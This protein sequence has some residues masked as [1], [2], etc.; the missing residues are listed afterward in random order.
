MSDQPVDPGAALFDT[1]GR[2]IKDGVAPQAAG[3][4]PALWAA[5][6]PTE[7]RRPAATAAEAETAAACFE[8]HSG[9]NVIQ[10]QLTVDLTTNDPYNVLEGSL[11]GGICT[12][13]EDLPWQVTQGSF[14]GGFL[15][16]VGQRGLVPPSSWLRPNWRAAAHTL[17]SSLASTEVQTPI[18]ACSA[19]MG[20]SL[21][22]GT[23]PFSRV[24]KLHRNFE[25]PVSNSLE[26]PAG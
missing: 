2:R 4:P 20:T 23:T 5:I 7:A 13:P 25:A 3:L 18:L 16:I 19:S 26:R 12:G 9:P 11:G 14:D 15:T 21:R 10:I 17:L 24:G 8:L 1:S 22:S 6:G